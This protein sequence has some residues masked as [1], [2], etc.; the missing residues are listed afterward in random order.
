MACPVRK[1]GEGPRIHPVPWQSLRAPGKEQDGRG[2]GAHP[3]ALYKPAHRWT[4]PMCG[5]RKSVQV[6]LY[7]KK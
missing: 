5:D 1:D 7:L 4:I 2:G 3:T 6:L